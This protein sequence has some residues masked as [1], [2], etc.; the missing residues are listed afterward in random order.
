MLLICVEDFPS[1]GGA[2]ARTSASGNYFE[3]CGFAFFPSA[4]FILRRVQSALCLPIFAIITQL[5]CIALRPAN[6]G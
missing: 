6:L 1:A 2:G 5:I 3:G 4:G